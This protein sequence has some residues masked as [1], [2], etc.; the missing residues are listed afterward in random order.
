MA[1]R[2][3]TA[4]TP[5]SAPDAVTTSTAPA[6][7]APATTKTRRRRSATTAPTR[8][9][10]VSTATA[11]IASAAA[12]AVTGSETISETIAPPELLTGLTGKQLA[13]IEHYLQ[14]GN[15][16]EAARRAG[17]EGSDNSLAVIGHKNLRKPKIAQL[18]QRRFDAVA[19]ASQEV[20]LR[21]SQQARGSMGDFV[22]VHSYGGRPYMTLEKAEKL[23]VMHLVKKMTQDG[24]TFS[25]ELYDSQKAL[26]QIAKLLGLFDTPSDA[27]MKMVEKRLDWSKVSEA[28]LRRIQ[29]GESLLMALLEPYLTPA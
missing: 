19:M 3:L 2:R 15:A 26:V 5:T 25:I 17:Y 20:V 10:Q 6:T 9:A 16:T 13:F 24:S 8:Q 23:G 18:I 21:L 22:E 12:A 27:T 4:S 7:A 14:C 1:T 11:S 29:N 28:Q